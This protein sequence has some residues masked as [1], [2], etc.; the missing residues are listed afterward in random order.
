[1]DGWKINYRPFGAR[2]V[3][4]GELLNFQLNKSEMVPPRLKELASARDREAANG[5]AMG[6]G[7][8]SRTGK[9]KQGWMEDEE[10]HD[11]DDELLY[12]YLYKSCLS[13]IIL[14]IYLWSHESVTITIIIINH[15]PSLW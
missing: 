1:M 15:Y 9:N 3:F 5:M 7:G 2:L 13:S 10:D 12:D 11:D 4:R 14:Y 8:V 6:F